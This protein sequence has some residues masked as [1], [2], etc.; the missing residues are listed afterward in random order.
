V[1]AIADNIEA[2]V[3]GRTSILSAKS[4]CD[5]WFFTVIGRR[6]RFSAAP[7]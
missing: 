2:I 3:V 7:T 4:T 6:V 1:A 5:R